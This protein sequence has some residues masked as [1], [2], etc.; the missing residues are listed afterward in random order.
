VIV[1][2]DI[3]QCCLVEADR[4]FRRVS[5]ALHGASSQKTV[6][7]ALF[8]IIFTIRNILQWHLSSQEVRT[9]QVLT[10]QTECFQI[11]ASLI[12]MVVLEIKIVIFQVKKYGQKVNE[13]NHKNISHRS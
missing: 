5:T 1:F 9:A 6:T 12:C 4:R 3:W 11:R 10:D 7:F 8:T 13:E 2:R